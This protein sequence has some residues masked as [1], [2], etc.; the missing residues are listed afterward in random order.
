M[1]NKTMNLT[2][3]SESAQSDLKDLIKGDKEAEKIKKSKEKVDYM[4]YVYM[5][6]EKEIT[7]IEKKYNLDMDELA[8]LLMKL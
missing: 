8:T 1:L 5:T 3:V 7:K 6:Y 4:D 2:I